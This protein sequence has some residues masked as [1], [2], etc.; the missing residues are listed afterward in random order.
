[1]ISAQHR[2]ICVAGALHFQ[3][4]DVCLHQAAKLYNIIGKI[5]GLLNNRGYSMITRIPMISIILTSMF[6]ALFML[7]RNDS[8]NYTLCYHCSTKSTARKTDINNVSSFPS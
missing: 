3:P 2:E 7:E 5:L 1:M 8:S 6:E 4:N